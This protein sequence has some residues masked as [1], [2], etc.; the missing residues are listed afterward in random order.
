MLNTLIFFIIYIVCFLSI[1][2]YGKLVT[3]IF[4]KEE[5]KINYFELSILGNIFFLIISFLIYIS[6]GFNL[7]LNFFVFF[8]GLIIYFFYKKKLNTISLKKI[9]LYLF[10]FFSALLISKTHED[11]AIY[12]LDGI[13]E[14]FDNKLTFGITNLDPK[15]SHVSP[16]SYVQALFIMPF[17]QEKIIHLPIYYI[18]ISTIGYFYITFKNSNQNQF[19]KFFCYFIFIFIIIKFSRLSE[20]GYD[21]IVQFLLIVVFHKIFFLQKNKNE[22]L[23]LTIIYLFAI[24]IKPIALLF[25]P[26]FWLIFF[27]KNFFQRFKIFLSKRLI[28]FSITIIGIIFFNSFARTGCVYYP[29]NSS[30]FS[31]NKIEW[32]AKNVMNLHNQHIENWAKGFYHQNI[33]KYPNIKSEVDYLKKYNWVKYWFSIHFFY[34][35]FEFILIIIFLFFLIYY[36]IFFKN[37]YENPKK[38]VFLGVIFVSF[39]S[40]LFWFNTI[41]QFRFGFASIL[42]FIFFLFSYFFNQNYQSNKK[43][44][45]FLMIIVILLF[46]IRNGVRINN[47]FARSDQYQFLSFPW[48]PGFEKKRNKLKTNFLVDEY[49]FYR[50]IKKN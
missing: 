9:T 46:N 13:V 27:T 7:Y 48:F 44:A 41:P 28:F 50:I 40:V 30:C 42:I 24:A 1:S 22:I 21:Y 14:I 10:L 43:F 12:H 31:K 26:F 6:Y 2:G 25:I 17:V 5:L 36:F 3:N 16:L 15:F 19:E 47:E 39:L 11:F 4:H 33:T 23:K 38:N 45:Y 20:F 49:K 29:I 34:K 35:I 8:F 18:F 37:K 32:S